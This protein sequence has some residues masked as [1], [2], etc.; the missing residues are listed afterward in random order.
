MKDKE[1]GKLTRS[2]YDKLTADEKWALMSELNDQIVHQATMIAELKELLALGT[3]EIYCPS[4][5]KQMHFLFPEIEALTQMQQKQEEDKVLVAEHERKVRKTREVAKLP[6]DTPATI[7]DHCADAPA[8]IMR[9]GIIYRKSS[10]TH[11]VLQVAKIP[12]RYVVEKHEWPIYEATVEDESIKEKTIVLFNEEEIEKIG[13]SPSL[14][15][16][17]I[18]SKFDDALPLYRQEEIFRRSGFALRRQRMASWVILYYQKLKPLERFFKKKLFQSPALYMD[19]S[20]VQVLDIKGPQGKPST[21]MFMTFTTGSVF[22]ESEKR[23]HDLVLFK[24]IQGRAHEVLLKD[25][26]DYNFDGYLMSDGLTG[27]H[28]YNEDKHARCWVHAVRYFKKAL[29]ASKDKCKEAKVL[30]S[31]FQELYKIENRLRS[32]LASGKLNKDAFLSQRKA[33]A[34]PVIDKFF[35]Y[36]VTVKDLFSQSSLMGKGFNYIFDCVDNLYKYLDVIEF[37]PDNNISERYAKTFSIG[38]KN[39]LF[40]QSITGCEASAFFYSLVENAKNSNISPDDYV[41]LVCTFGPY[42]KT[43]EDW[44]SLLPWNADFSRLAAIRDK[45][46]YAVADPDRKEPYFIVGHTH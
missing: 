17:I 13:G 36:A 12:A 11:E 2:N 40:A 41:E 46:K 39:W 15:S 10:S 3:Y 30:L 22:D 33:E 26:D 38:R 42:A 34:A 28:F 7:V 9:N 6:N 32:E 1:I 35:S 20:P 23:C 18:V 31:Y 21:N 44:N 25:L 24:C 14:I 29:L 45:R 27:Y 5:E 4:S 37:T 19:E 43:E 8:E 16:N